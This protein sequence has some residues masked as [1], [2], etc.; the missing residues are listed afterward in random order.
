MPKPGVNWM[1]RWWDIGNFVL[2]VMFQLY[3]RFSGTRS[4]RMMTGKVSYKLS[5]LWLSNGGLCKWFW[6]DYFSTSITCRLSRLQILSDFEWGFAWPGPFLA[7]SYN[8]PDHSWSLIYDFPFEW[9][10]HWSTSHMQMTSSCIH[11]I[12]SKS[13]SFPFKTIPLD[14][15]FNSLSNL[16][17][18]PTLWRF[19]KRTE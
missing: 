14:E 11:W 12:S 19:L 9:F 10:A 7:N 16:I 5:H 3:F 13:D 18:Y 6:R 8:L 17:L 4:A 1:S 15:Q 2:I